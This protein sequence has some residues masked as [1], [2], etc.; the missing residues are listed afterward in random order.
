MSHPSHI[1]DAEWDVRIKLAAAYRLAALNRWTDGILTHFSA[2]VPGGE[3]HFLINAFGLTFDEVTASNLVKVDIDGNI[4][5]DPSGLG[6]NRAGYIIHSAI[7]EAR[8]DALA[9]LHTHTRDGIAVASQEQGLLM[10]SQ[11]SLGFYKRLAYHPYEGIVFDEDE[12]HRLIANMG[13]HN[14]LI[15][16]NHGLLTCGDSIEQAFRLLGSLERACSI[17][18][19]AQSGGV[20]LAYPDPAVAEKMLHQV[21]PQ[22]AHGTPSFLERFWNAQIRQLDRIDPSYRQ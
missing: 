6:I 17:Q 1:S 22:P 13:S 21:P 7:H 5:H 19:A 20:A 15:L 18:I 3:H 16:R 9:V 12:K 11:N 10:L 14:A 4:L 2:R 8:P